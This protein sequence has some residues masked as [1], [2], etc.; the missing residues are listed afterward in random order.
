[1]PWPSN[2]PDPLE[3]RRRKLAEKERLVAE[4]M[5]LLTKQLYPSGETA[6]PPVVKPIEP[7][8]WRLEEESRPVDPMP[9]RKR[10]LARQRQRDMMVFFIAVAVLLIVMGILV[11]VAY[12]HNSSPANGL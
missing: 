12:V 10:H 6:P 9:I 8:V 4:Q 3:D 7:P 2:D 1:M 5:S 11:W